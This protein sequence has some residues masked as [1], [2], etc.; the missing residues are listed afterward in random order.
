MEFFP[1]PRARTEEPDSEPELTY[2]PWDGAPEGVLGGLV[3]LERIRVPARNGQVVV[4]V[5]E[6]VAY[7][8]GL[9]LRMKLLA[10]RPRG[11]TS[12]QWELVKRGVW[13]RDAPHA[14]EKEAG[15]S[16]EVGASRPPDR[17][18][19]WL[20]RFGVRFPDGRQATTLDERPE[21]WP[22]PYPQSPVLIQQDRIGSSSHERIEA[23]RTLWLWPL[24]PPR[25]LELALEWPL[26]GIPL[27][28]AE[29]DGAAIVAAAARACPYWEDEEGSATTPA[30][31]R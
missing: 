12:G 16:P 18:P 3:P 20:L 8:E 19:D 21:Q 1:P 9:E 11:M 5:T 29:L 17:H 7:P 22:T 13:G 4:V 24:P 31:A 6:A 2:Q 14:W 25:P 10:R 15:A 28:F 26:M 27:T 30:D 23:E